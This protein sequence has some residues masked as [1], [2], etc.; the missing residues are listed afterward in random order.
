MS[1]PAEALPDGDYWDYKDLTLPLD[2][3][4]I[5]EASPA[6]LQSIVYVKRQHELLDS[7]IHAWIRKA[8]ECKS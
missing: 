5:F 6:D 4:I 3:K 8:K 2:P 7:A 1:A